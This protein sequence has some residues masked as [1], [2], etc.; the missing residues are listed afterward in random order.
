MS[1]RH[2]T[3]LNVLARITAKVVRNNPDSEVVLCL[4][5]EDA[6]AL[7]RGTSDVKGSPH[8]AQLQKK[9]RVSGCCIEHADIP[10]RGFYFKLLPEG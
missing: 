10:Q 4:P 9:Y 3:T 2:L 8:V 6:T 5:A 1:N 7:L